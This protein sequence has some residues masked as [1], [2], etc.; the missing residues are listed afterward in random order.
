M[1]NC[2]QAMYADPR[3]MAI[4]HSV[5]TTPHLPE[6]QWASESTGSLQSYRQDIQ[7][8]PFYEQ[9][10]T[11]TYSYSSQNYYPTWQPSSLSAMQSLSP[12]QNPQQSVARQTTHSSSS[13][14][15]PPSHST[16]TPRRTDKPNGVVS[17]GTSH[18][19]EHATGPGA[20]LFKPPTSYVLPSA[21]I[22]T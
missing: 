2:S 14:N 12:M 15:H 5:T 9:F 17:R 19:R 11:S 3:V 4:P 20:R 16:R 7:Y 1:D 6:H 18:S 22:L 8:E 13:R 10:Q 21:I